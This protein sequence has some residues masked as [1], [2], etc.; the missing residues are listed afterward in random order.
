MSTAIHPD[1]GEFIPWIM[2]LSSFLPCNIPI[3]FGFII[4]KPTPFNTIFVNW[5]N[6]TYNALMNYGNRNATS[7]YTTEDILKSYIVASGSS[8]A[9]ALGIRKAL[10]GYSRN[11]VGARLILLNSFSSFWACATAGYLNAFFMRK[12]ELEKGVE[13]QDNDGK[14]VG[15]SKIA[16]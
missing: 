6:Q 2:R 14:I 7:L 10:S 16:A 8:I 3:A 15:K 1:T 5:V 4:A 12:T 9:V 13:I 11:T